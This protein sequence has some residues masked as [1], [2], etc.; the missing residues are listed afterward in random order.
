M[1]LEQEGYRCEQTWK[2]FDKRMHLCA[3]GG[4]DEL[5]PFCGKPEQFLADRDKLVVLQSDQVPFF[6][7]VRPTKQLFGP[8][9]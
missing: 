9:E 2:L 1:S 3:F 4:L 6:V 8:E 7:K 5:T